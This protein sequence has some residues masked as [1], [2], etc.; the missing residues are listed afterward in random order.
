M[1]KI[2]P[3]LASSFFKDEYIIF[4]SYM[5]LLFALTCLKFHVNYQYT[6]LSAISG[7]DFLYSK[8]RFNI[9]YDFLSIRFNSR[10]R[11]KIIVNEIT[12]IF[13]II[14]LFKNA[15]W[16]EREIWDLYGI[17]FESHTDLRRI[18]T[19][20][21][22]EGYPLRKDYPISGFVA[23][24]YDVKKKKIAIERLELQQDFRYFTHGDSWNGRVI[25][26]RSNDCQ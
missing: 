4:V 20:Y 7:V 21:G 15:N 8:N 6:L 12:P 22:F 1:K 10:L 16:W 17:Y 5:Q 26:K 23:L 14:S 11:V 18:L 24:R 2:V 25:H 19:D 9:V 13:S 3:I